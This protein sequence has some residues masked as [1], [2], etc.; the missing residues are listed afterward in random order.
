MTHP[1]AAPL[2]GR[3]AVISGGNRG[4]GLEIA[5]RYVAAGASVLICA[6]DQALL[7]DAAGELERMAGAEQLIAACAA[8][9]SRPAE[10]DG[11]I[12]TA[13]RRFGRLDIL[14]SNAGIA[15]PGGSLEHLEWP[16]WVRTME[17]NLFG[18]VLLCRAVLPHFKQRGRGKIIQISGGGATRPLPMR[19]AYAASKAAVIRFMETLAE[20]TRGDGIE[21]NA[22]APGALNTR[23][24]DDMLAAGP[25]GLGDAAYEAL[26]E[27]KRGGGVPLA[28]GAEL[29]VFLGS[30]ASDGISG[31][32]LS[33]VWDRWRDLPRHATELARTDVYTLRRITPRD[34]GLRF[35]DDP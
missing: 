29:A 1:T 19:A 31:R 16:A 17:V 9:V 20:E 6:R 4:L 3:S 18:P 35:E 23:M 10:A 11:V 24:L 14:V 32:L 5:R 12:D 26:L 22:I 8:D 28:K 25:E 21:V 15:G 33:A 13:L 30:A 27:Q 34:R 2:A 7:A